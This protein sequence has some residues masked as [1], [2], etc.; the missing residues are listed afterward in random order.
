MKFG[1]KHMHPQSHGFP[2]TLAG[3]GCLLPSHVLRHGRP[4]AGAHADVAGAPGEIN[5][6]SMTPWGTPNS[7]LV[8]VGLCWFI[9]ENPTKIH[10]LGDRPPYKWR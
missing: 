5:S 10:D 7:W 4:G 6:G 3:P 9:D 8:Y 2:V 1:Y